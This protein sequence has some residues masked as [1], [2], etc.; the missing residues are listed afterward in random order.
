M[1]DIEKAIK[2]LQIERECVSRD[3]ARDCGNCDLA[4]DRDWLLSVYD[5]ALELLKE[6]GPVKPIKSKLSFTRGFMWEI[7]DCGCCGNQLRSF[8]K[9]CDQC[10]KAVKQDG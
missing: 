1:P 5:D 9:Y 6:Q 10:G 4:Q 3:C 2:G 7:W 8:A